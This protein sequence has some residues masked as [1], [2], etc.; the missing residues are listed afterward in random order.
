[1]ALLHTVKQRPLA[2]VVAELPLR[3]GEQRE[4]QFLLLRTEV[5]VPDDDRPR[6]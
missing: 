6:R 4:V 5:I 1:M 3:I 2:D